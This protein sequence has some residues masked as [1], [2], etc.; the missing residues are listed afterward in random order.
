M[1][2][3]VETIVRAA[4]EVQDDI[5]LDVLIYGSGVAE[6]NAKKLAQ[7]LGAKNIKF[8][9]RVSSEGMR[10][11]YERSDFQLVTLK[12]RAVFRMTIPSK[13]QASLAN[14]VPVITTVQGDLASICAEKGI[15][16]VAQPES[17]SSLA[18]AFRQASALG[19]T[20]RADMASKAWQFYWDHLAEEKATIKIASR[21]TSIAVHNR[22]K[23]N[24]K[25]TRG[26]VHEA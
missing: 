11:V 4:A 22:E 6:E 2:Q 16:L 15:G 10:E 24:A 25:I 18:S 5:A 9:G 19:S 1:M 23:R 8:M 26:E 3:D 14:G 21:L 7:E 13:F 12:D 20:G 17:P